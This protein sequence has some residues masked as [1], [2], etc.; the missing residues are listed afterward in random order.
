MTIKISI[1]NTDIGTI[2]VHNTQEFDDEGRVK[3]DVYDLRGNPISLETAP[4]IDE[5][6]HHRSYGAA[7]LTAEIMDN[8]PE[9][10]LD[11]YA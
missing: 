7:S 2:G 9:D 10:R 6:W 1:N 11:D 4:Q 5:L 3:Y 8:I